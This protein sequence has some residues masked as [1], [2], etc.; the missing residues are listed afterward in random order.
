MRRFAPAPARI[1]IAGDW[2]ADT[3]HG[4]RAI[5]H[6][7]RQGAEVIIHLG[8][9]GYT[10]S[11][12]YLDTLDAALS[13]RDLLLGFVDGN[14]EDFDWLLARPVATD[15]L[16]YLRSHIA[17]LPR[18]ARWRWGRTRCLAV[19]GAHSIDSFLRIPGRSWWPQEAITPAEVDTIIAGGGAEVMF[20][21]D[22][23]TGVTIPG[24]DRDRHGFPAA[25]LRAAEQ[26][27]IRLRRIVDAV[28]PQRLWH[29]H[30][31]HRY[32]TVLDGVDYR[33]TVDGLGRDTDPID[34]NM[35]VIDASRLAGTTEPP[36]SRPIGATG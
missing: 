17:H 13:D 2:H 8:D 24:M 15:G 31:H 33:T 26:N 35:V 11:A 9:F 14:H 30:F 3:D 23:P 10:F 16:R 4:V 20:C 21:H 19:G 27:R 12:A 22:C 18:G 28:R 36:H 1:A 34:D 32:Q 25:E 6:A 5:E 29:G 7:S